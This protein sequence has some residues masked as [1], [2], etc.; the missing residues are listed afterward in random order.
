MIWVIFGA[1]I[2]SNLSFFCLLCQPWIIWRT[3]NEPTQKSV[4][5]HC[6]YVRLCTSNAHT[7]NEER[8]T[9]KSEGQRSKFFMGKI[10]WKTFL[11]AD[12]FLSIFDAHR[13]SACSFNAAPYSTY[14]GSFF[15]L[16]LN[17]KCNAYMLLKYSHQFCV[18]STSV[19]LVYDCWPWQLRNSKRKR[20]K[21]FFG[22]S[23]IGRNM[24]T[25]WFHLFIIFKKD[26]SVTQNRQTKSSTRFDND[27]RF[28]TNCVCLCPSRQPQRP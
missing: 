6:E 20:K 16:L 22:I 8:R 10:K 14:V 4:E 2:P 27:E 3:T 9:C 12:F 13:T 21:K 5:K 23:D 15:L 1:Q 26:V 25:F 28:Q 18:L 7:A 19:D 24:I 17:F 11:I